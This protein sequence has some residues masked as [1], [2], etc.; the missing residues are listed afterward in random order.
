MR[1]EAILIFP[2]SAVS[3]AI[4]GLGGGSPVEALGGSARSGDRLTERESPPHS[5]LSFLRQQEIFQ[6][7][8]HARGTRAA[9]TAHIHTG[10]ASIDRHVEMRRMIFFFGVHLV[11]LRLKAK[12][13]LFYFYWVFDF[14]KYRL[15]WEHPLKIYINI[16]MNVLIQK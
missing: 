12:W 7:R 4:R 15:H 5:Q 10:T 2:L 3:T 16:F 8:T 13:Q 14:K 6:H 1:G 11:H 9:L